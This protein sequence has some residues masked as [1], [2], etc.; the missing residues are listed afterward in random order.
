MGPFNCL[1]SPS[2]PPASLRDRP[3]LC[4]SGQALGPAHRMY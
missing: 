4:G 3:V 2:G 1:L